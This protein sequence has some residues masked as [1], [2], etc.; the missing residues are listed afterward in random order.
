MCGNVQFVSMRHVYVWHKTKHQASSTCFHVSIVL[1]TRRGI[2]ESISLG[3]GEVACD[4]PSPNGLA[5]AGP[6]LL[7]ICFSAG[8]PG[9]GCLTHA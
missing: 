2:R 1:A 4:C 7:R 8:F 3:D 6:R 5:S 9:C